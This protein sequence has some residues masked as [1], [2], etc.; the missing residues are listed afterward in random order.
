MKQSK[1][2]IE[3]EYERERELSNES[4][5][6]FRLFNRFSFIFINRPNQQA[7]AFRKAIED[8]KAAQ[9]YGVEYVTIPDE[10]QL[11]NILDEGRIMSADEVRRIVGFKEDS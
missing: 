4:K 11:V 1:S 9:R 10:N 7:E 2:F 3:Q 5:P 8:A 6:G